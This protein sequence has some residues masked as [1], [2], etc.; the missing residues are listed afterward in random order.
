MRLW[1]A[2][3]I[4]NWYFVP[5]EERAPQNLLKVS[6]VASNLQILLHKVRLPSL[7]NPY[8]SRLFPRFCL[9]NFLLQTLFLHFFFGMG[10]WFHISR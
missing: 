4:K 6:V 2:R 1:L 9:L 3:F 8:S 5:L 10:L 7:V